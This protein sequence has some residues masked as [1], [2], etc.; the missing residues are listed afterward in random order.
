MSG[1]GWG[2]GKTIFEP[3]GPAPA[4]IE[5]Q[6]C[7]RFP[8]NPKP[9]SE[10][11]A[12]KASAQAKPSVATSQ[13]PK[14]SPTTPPKASPSASPST[15]P[16]VCRADRTAIEKELMAAIPNVPFYGQTDAAKKGEPVTTRPLGFGMR[17]PATATGV[18]EIGLAGQGIGMGW[19]IEL[20]STCRTRAE[21][22]AK[23]SQKKDACGTK[24]V[25]PGALGD[26]SCVGSN[27]IGGCND[28][29]VSGDP[30]WGEGNAY[31][32]T[33]CADITI[34]SNPTISSPIEHGPRNKPDVVAAT[35]A[36]AEKWALELGKIAVAAVNKGCGAPFR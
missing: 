8:D 21:A 6:S 35:R 9:A 14:P 27:G 11:P 13:Q 26:P 30:Y 16:Q 28:C 18:V 20:A 31:V 5:P 32:V 23:F 22:Q 19:S 3:A 29:N 12:A 7:T 33:A 34:W 24:N 1:L 10:A 4:V 36:A 2:P 25:L 17:T 15:T